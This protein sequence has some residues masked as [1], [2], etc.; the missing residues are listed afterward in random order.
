MEIANRGGYERTYRDNYCKWT[1]V[2]RHDTGAIRGGV[3]CY[4]AGG[5]QM[6][7]WA[8]FAR[9]FYSRED[10]G[11]YWTQNRLFRKRQRGWQAKMF[12]QVFMR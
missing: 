4:R 8:K 3:S 5:W 7:T 12:I 9:R 6:G 11:T 2:Q 10:R 1:K